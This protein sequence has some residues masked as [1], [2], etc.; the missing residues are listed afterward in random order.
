MNRKQ[1]EARRTDFVV[2]KSDF[3]Q[4]AF[5]H[6]NETSPLLEGQVRLAVDTFALTANNITYAL[7][8][9]DMQY[10]N[11]FPGDEDGFGRVPVWGFANIVESRCEGLELGER[12]YG[13]LPIST[14]F[15]ATPVSVSASGFVD[16]ADHRCTRSIISTR[17]LVATLHT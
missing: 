1:Q 10:W 4:Q 8:G 11:F 14:D 15:I 9:D 16:G 13:F 5:R 2:S 7:V 6:S 12:I 17:K 3:S